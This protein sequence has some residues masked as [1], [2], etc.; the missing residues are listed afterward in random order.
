V[1]FVFVH[2]REFPGSASDPCREPSL[3][4]GAIIDI[5]LEEFLSFDCNNPETA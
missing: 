2:V 5:P 4:V 3:K 1:V